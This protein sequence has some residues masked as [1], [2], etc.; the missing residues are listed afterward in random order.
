MKNK[1]AFLNQYFGTKRYLYQDDKRVAHMH[2]VNGVY[3]LQGHHKTKWSG[4]KL[5]F[6]S[7]QEFMNCIQKY[8]LSLEEDNQLTLF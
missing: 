7:E 2:I 1:K 6:N 4:I 8:E 3:Y 5:T